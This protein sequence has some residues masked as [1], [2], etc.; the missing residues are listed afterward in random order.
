MEVRTCSHD[1]VSYCT[2]TEVHY[3]HA[4]CPC[5]KCKGKAVSRSTEYRHRQLQAE[6][7]AAHA[8][9]FVATDEQEDGDIDMDHDQDDN[10]ASPISCMETSVPL[11][12]A[13]AHQPQ[14]VGEVTHDDN[15]NSAPPLAESLLQ[16]VFGQDVD[17]DIVVS[18]LK[19]FELLEDMNGSQK[20]FLDV[21]KFGR[22]LYCK[23]D[24]SLLRRWPTTWLGCMNILK[25]AGYKEPT[26]YYVCL[27]ESHPNLWDSMNSP[28]DV[29]KYCRKPGTIQYHYLCLK[30]KVKRWCSSKEFCSKMTDHWNNKEKWLHSTSTSIEDDDKIYKELWDGER[31]T[32]LKW[33]WDPQEE[34]MLPTYCPICN[35]VVSSDMINCA[36]RMESAAV[37]AVVSPSLSIECPH[38]FSLFKHTPRYARGDP[39]NIALI[40]HWDGFQPFTTSPKHSCGKYDN[41][42]TEK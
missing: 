5:W 2:C 16:G 20:N 14:A 13:S 34:W 6:T 28:N 30:D 29:C 8:P 24:Q 38:C 19:A 37:G 41:H 11:S 32:E 33:F 31:F 7:S 15:I 39:R 18:V 22:D 17:K 4:H 35:N 12:T 25:E 10:S 40:G 26:T 21:L 1:R 27:D 42:N 36:Q 3:V 23:D 9:T